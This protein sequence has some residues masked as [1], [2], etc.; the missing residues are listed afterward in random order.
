MVLEV[1]TEPFEGLLKQALGEAGIKTTKTQRVEIALGLDSIVE[2]RFI[3]SAE[4]RME[5]LKN[6]VSIMKTHELG[7][8]ASSL[9]QI[10]TLANLLKAQFSTVGNEVETITIDAVHGVVDRS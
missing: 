8:F 6:A 5:N 2:E 9:L 4:L 10:Q 1:L 7:S 3:E